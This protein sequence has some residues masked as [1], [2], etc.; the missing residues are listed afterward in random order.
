MLRQRKKKKDV[1]KNVKALPSSPGK[2]MY[3][4]QRVGRHHIPS[5]ADELVQADH[6]VLKRK[7]FL[8]YFKTT[9]E[10]VQP[11]EAMEIITEQLSISTEGNS[12]VVDITEHVAAILARSNLMEGNVTVFVVGSTASI[13][14]TEFEPGL[15]QDIPDALDRIAP[16]TARYHHDNRWHDGNG[17]AHVRAALTGCSLTIPFVRGKLMLGTWQQLVLIDHDNRP[18]RRTVVVQLVGK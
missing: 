12:Q 16:R 8:H 11:G 15:Q 13:T 1:G 2:E 17:H 10:T 7:K 3:R 9:Y 5:R 14:T 6:I 18:R 4:S